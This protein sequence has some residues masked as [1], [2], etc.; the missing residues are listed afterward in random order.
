MNKIKT[1]QD[2]EAVKKKGLSTIYPKKTKIIIG[3]AT[4]G[5][6]SGA[7]EVFDTIREELK[8]QKLDAV[9]AKTGCIG[10]CEKEPLVDILRSGKTRITFAELN[11]KKVKELISDLAKNEIKEEQAF[12]ELEGEAQIKSKE[13][14]GIPRYKDIAFYK[15]QQKIALRNCGFI[16]PESIEEYIARGG[17]HSL[18]KALTGMAQ[19]E[20]IE[21]IKRSGLRGRGGAGFSTGIKWEFCRKAEGDIKYIICNADEGDPGAYM[22]RSILEGDPHSVLEGMIIGAYAIGATEGYIYVRAEYPLAIKELTTALKQAGEYGLLGENIFDSSFDFTIKI[23]QGGGAF[24]CGEETALLASIEGKLGEPR[25][26]P[27]FPAQKGLWDKPTNINNVETWANVPEIISRGADWYAKIGTE[28]SKGTKVFALVGKITNT[29]L[30]EVPMG[31]TLRDV[32]YEIGG[33]ILG[34]KELKAVQTGGPSGGC[35]PKDL[36]DLPIDYE[37]LTEAGSMMGSGGM[38]VMDENTCMVDVAKYFLDFLR[39]ESC[40]KCT[41]CREGVA[42]MYEILD[43]ITKGQGK[44]EDIELLE[45]LAHYIKDASLCGLGSTAPNPVLSTLRFFKDEYEAHIKENRCPAGVCQELIKYLIDEGKCTGCLL[46][47]KE[48][49]QE[50]ISGERKKTHKIDQTQCIKCGICLDVC[51]FDAVIVK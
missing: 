39:D 44:E 28:K 40:G 31:I 14:N 46:C 38:I 18:Y 24:V 32:I 22:D 16:D 49:P 37:Q 11:P 23:K 42:R 29:G 21:E 35:I 1:L 48:C 17:Y 8:N 47:K 4:C 19:E 20:V 33:G 36:I 30:V 5:L 13:G 41:P 3:M 27:P 9:L 10:I 6:A 34:G 43:R 45:D 25:P 2:L 51:N 7:Q 50:A 12:G 15:K 26:R